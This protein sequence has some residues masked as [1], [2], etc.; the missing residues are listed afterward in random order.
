MMP[1]SQRLY[2]VGFSMSLFPNIETIIFT[3]PLE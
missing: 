3:S 1:T 2:P